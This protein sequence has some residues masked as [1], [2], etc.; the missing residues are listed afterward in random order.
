MVKAIIK[1]VLGTQYYGE[2]RRCDGY[3]QEDSKEKLLKR[4]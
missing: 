4:W 2:L 1:R 3:Y